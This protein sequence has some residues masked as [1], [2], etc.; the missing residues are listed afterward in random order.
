MRYANYFNLF[1]L[2]YFY[3][4]L[5]FNNLIFNDCQILD[6]RLYAKNAN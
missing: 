2:K 3:L 4:A 5:Q 6:F 1:F